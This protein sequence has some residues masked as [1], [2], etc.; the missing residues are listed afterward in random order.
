MAIDFN[1]I[2]PTLKKAFIHKKKKA[3]AVK[4]NGSI[5]K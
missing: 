4:K 5:R 3:A 1:V 2:Q